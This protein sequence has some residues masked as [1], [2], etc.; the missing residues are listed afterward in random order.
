[1]VLRGL[2]LAVLGL[3]GI[4][5][6][7]CTKFHPGV[8]FGDGTPVGFSFLDSLGSGATSF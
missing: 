4:R 2:V 8:A 1:M 6:Q 5:T 3:V 7:A